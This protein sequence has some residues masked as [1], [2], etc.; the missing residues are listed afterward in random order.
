MPSDALVNNTIILEKDLLYPTDKSIYSNKQG[1]PTFTFNSGDT[2]TSYD[3]E[4]SAQIYVDGQKIS[5]SL[6][7]DVLTLVQDGGKD[8]YVPDPD[9]TQYSKWLFE[10]GKLRST[11]TCYCKRINY[12]NPNYTKCNQ[13]LNCRKHQFHS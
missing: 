7:N 10:T 8:P 2:N 6:C 13:S 3:I 11:A 12:C 9:T 1:F 4:I 5:S